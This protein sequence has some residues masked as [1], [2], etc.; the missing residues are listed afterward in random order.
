MIKQIT[1]DALTVGMY[2]DDLNCG[3]LDHPF[4]RN[5][6]LVKDAK[7]LAKL[8]AL[9]VQTLYIDTERGLD[10]IDAPSRQE[11]E[12]QQQQ[13]VEAIIEAPAPA[14][15]EN[16]G[17]DQELVNAHEI[18]RDAH[19]VIGELMSGIKLGQRI[20]VAAAEEVVER[21]TRSLIR[22]P[23]ALMALGRIRSVDHYTFEHSINVCTLMV[24]F[25]HY[26]GL[27]PETIRSIGTGAMLHDIGKVTIADQI[28]NKPG[29]LTEEEFRIMQG[30]VASGQQLL[31]ECEV[32]PTAL[33][34]VAEHH[35]RFDGSGYPLG[36]KGEQISHYGHMAAIVDVYDALTSDRCYHDAI[37]PT[38][39]LRKIYDWSQH[40][41]HPQLAQQFIRFVG[42]YPAG[43]VVELASGHLALV[44]ERSDDR[45]NPRVRIFYDTL[46]KRSVEPYDFDLAGDQ[47]HIHRY[48]DLAAWGLDAQPLLRRLLR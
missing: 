6:F 5:R 23:D 18:T 47:D 16:L 31:R 36:L 15:V 43:S 38:A 35:E 13:A 32:E 2:I 11:V 48:A 37:A 41:F 28:L 9:P 1:I 7:T 26:L 4:A 42:V 40:Q 33:A 21:M 14:P 12:E 29:K 3:W 10:V 22:N 34:V 46:R 8:R 24:A 19:R 30:H 39:V 25:A 27:H 20:R 17:F 45:L 44:L